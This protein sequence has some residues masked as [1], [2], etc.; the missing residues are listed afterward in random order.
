[1]PIIQEAF[2]IPNDI[3]TKLLTGE[4]RRIGGII[5]YA[6]GPNKGQIVKHLEPID[7]KPAQQAQSI[8]AKVIQFAKRNKKVLIVS[9]VAV[10]AV[11]VGS[12]V[13]CKVKNRE[14][15][16]VKTFRSELKTY[17]EEVRTGALKLSSIENL[18]R[19]LEAVKS[20]KDSGNIIIELSTEELDVLVNRIY[21]YTKTLAEMNEYHF[22]A[23]DLE[24]YDDSMDNLYSYLT[25]QKQI[26]ETA[27]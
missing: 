26:F 3:M 12:F 1:M 16:V 4:Y 24:K 21:E 27:A 13:Y 25:V 18:L 2:D 17:I 14:P 5:R 11:T 10:A 15:E 9:G 7:L 6:T 23:E 22:S 8:G 20:H 19:A